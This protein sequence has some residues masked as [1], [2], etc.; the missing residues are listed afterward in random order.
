MGSED[1]KLTQEQ[2]QLPS[3]IILRSKTDSVELKQLIPEDAEHYFQLV[4]SDRA[5]LSQFGDVTAEKYPTVEAVRESIVHPAN[6]NKY[7]FGIWDGEVMVG[8]INLIPAENNR[9]E[10]GTWIAKAHTGHQYAARAGS[11][12]I[13]FVFKQLQL[14]EVFAK[15]VVGNEASRKSAERSGFILTGEVEEDGVKKWMY[16]LSNPRSKAE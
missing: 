14:D 8:S 7:R 11:L 13:D 2:P 10:A 6:P 4:D 16:V 1:A 5:H 9:T 12:L 3:R 15:I